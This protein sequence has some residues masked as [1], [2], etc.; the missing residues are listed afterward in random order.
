MSAGRLGRRPGGLAA[1]VRAHVERHDTVTIERDL[2]AATEPDAIACMFEAFCRDMLGA[3]VAGCLRYASS[4]GVVAGLVLDGGPPVLV[5]VHRRTVGATRLRA[6]QAVMT[7]LRERGF[8]CP[9]PLVGPTPMGEGLATIETWEDV[10]ATRDA[11]DPSVRR[12]LAAGLATLIRSVPVT[13][14]HEPLRQDAWAGL[15]PPPHNALF[16]F[17]ATAAGAEWIDD[18][19][20][21]ARRVPAAGVRAVG[22]ADWRAEHVRFDG[23]RIVM[24]YD[25][26]SLRLDTEAAHVGG[27][28]VGFPANFEGDDVARAPSMDELRAF[29]ADYE[30]ARDA[31][32]TTSERRA[33]MAGALFTLAYTARCEHALGDRAASAFRTLLA[34]S[35]EELLREA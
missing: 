13:P 22:H 24:V 27:A 28:A 7:S 1:A 30:S 9:R 25:W 20:R 10:G 4:V 5:K 32:F 18:F 6:V 19:A 16:D 35:G 12:A 29:V 23:D 3:R 14:A 2:L 8:P 17:E 31:G 21:A 15:F 11:H 34:A 26:D 33:V